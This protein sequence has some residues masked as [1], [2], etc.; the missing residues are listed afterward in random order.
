M[1]AGSQNPQLSGANN[2]KASAVKILTSSSA[3]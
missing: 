3:C 2:D 1:N